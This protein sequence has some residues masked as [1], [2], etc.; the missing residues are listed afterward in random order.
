MGKKPPNKLVW[1]PSPAPTEPLLVRAKRGVEN[2][3]A[4]E[5]S[6]R[7]LIARAA[8]G[9]EIGVKAQIVRLLWRAGGLERRVAAKL[10]IWFFRT[11]RFTKA[12]KGPQPRP[13]K[14]IRTPTGERKE[15]LVP[16]N[17][18]ALDVFHRL[19]LGPGSPRERKLGKAIKDAARFYGITKKQVRD[20]FDEYR[21]DLF[22]ISDETSSWI[23]DRI[24]WS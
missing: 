1:V 2:R 14:C 7:L 16:R 10:L 22:W 11:G 17:E 3:K 19:E 20:C 5:K 8:F 9:D 18:I 4:A 24:T 13:I 15:A 21:E 23:S 6:V 12:R